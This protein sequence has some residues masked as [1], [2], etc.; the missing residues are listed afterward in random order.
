MSAF[1]ARKKSSYK[2]FQDNVEL[3]VVEP[4][5]LLLRLVVNN[6]QETENTSDPKQEETPDIDMNDPKGLPP[7]PKEYLK[8]PEHDWF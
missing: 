1:E 8:F 7:Q 4:T 2:S 6:D 3:T 5:K